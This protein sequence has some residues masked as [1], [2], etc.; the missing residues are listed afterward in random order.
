VQCFGNLQLIAKWFCYQGSETFSYYSLDAK[1]SSRIPRRLVCGP[2]CTNEIQINSV[3]MNW[4][5][6]KF[7]QAGERAS[8][9]S[10][11]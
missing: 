9:P 8:K 6:H 10:V 4:K 7:R 1:H 11:F 2:I 5:G 3:L